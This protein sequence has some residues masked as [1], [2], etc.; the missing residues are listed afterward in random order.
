MYS[1]FKTTFAFASLRKSMQILIPSRLEWSFRSVIPSIFLSLTSSATFEIRRAL[2]TRYGSSVTIIL[3]FP[4]G[5]VSMFVTARTRIFPRPVLY[6]S[7]IPLL[8]RIVAPVGKSGPFTISRISSIVV[9][10]CSSM[11]LSI[12]LT[13]ASTTSLRLWGGI[14]VAIPTAIPEVPFTRRFG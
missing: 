6:A 1:K 2:F 11:V 9:S 8:P 10:R 12:I 13:T 5:R 14:L 3:D 4:F 7:S